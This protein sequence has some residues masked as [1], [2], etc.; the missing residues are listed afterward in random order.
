MTE[1]EKKQQ[2]AN[3]LIEIEDS[4]EELAHLRE[5]ALRIADN[6]DD[7][8]KKIR[9]HAATNTSRADFS[10]EFDLVNR[11]SLESQTSLN[12]IEIEKLIEE[13]R[14]E[15]KKLFNLIERKS[16]LSNSGLSISIPID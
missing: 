2:R 10:S 14:T 5:K 3:L 11:I 7:L 1:R 12:F 15:R 13:M 9:G 8:T 16:Q 6:L 4:Q